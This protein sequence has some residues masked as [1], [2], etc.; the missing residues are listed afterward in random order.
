MKAGL[1]VSLIK[2]VSYEKDKRKGGKVM[3][4]HTL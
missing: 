2:F 3:D 1:V 4:S